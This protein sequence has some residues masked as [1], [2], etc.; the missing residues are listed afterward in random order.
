MTI[1]ITE[2]F[3]SERSHEVFVCTVH[4]VPVAENVFQPFLSVIYE[5]KDSQIYNTAFL[6]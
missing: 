4:Q 3:F 1:V 5:D 2:Y 6:T